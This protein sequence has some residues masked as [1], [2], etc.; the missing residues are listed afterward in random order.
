MLA[1]SDAHGNP[2]GEQPRSRSEVLDRVGASASDSQ[3]RA[4]ECLGTQ[5]AGSTA[6]KT[7]RSLW[8][9]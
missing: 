6:R 9:F 8:R 2:S 5:N 1:Y 3:S 7:Q 4:I